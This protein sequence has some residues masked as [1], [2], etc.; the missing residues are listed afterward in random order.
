MA[1]QHPLDGSLK[2]WDQVSSRHANTALLFG[3]GLSIHV[4]HAFDYR[5]LYQQAMGPGGLTAEDVGLF[6]K[7]DTTN[8]EL[9]LAGLNT[10]IR[11]CSAIGW[12]VRA[13]RT[14]YQSVQHGLAFAVRQVH[15]ERDEIAPAALP[16]IQKYL[17][18]Q[19]A[20]FTTS[21]DLI[22]YWAMAHDGDWGRLRDCLW[23]DGF[24]PRDATLWPGTTGVWFLHGALH[25]VEMSSGRTRKLQSELLRNILDQFGDPVNGDREARALIVSEGQ[26]AD[27]LRAIRRN[28]YLSQALRQLERCNQPLIVFGSSLSP[29]DQ[30]LVDAINVNAKGPLLI[31]MLSDDTRNLR[32]RQRELHARLE[33][34]DLDFFDAATHPLGKPA[35]RREP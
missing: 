8:F 28:D 17:K 16:T 34:E 33:T 26:S 20:V 25:L 12:D 7:L 10:S 19:A 9:V 1:T 24:D 23:G 30:H 32:K 22:V 11:V 18:Q 6:H 27:K 21:Y 4:W 14:R 2:T 29:Q 35:L 31:S 15:I 5:S 3:N 13:L